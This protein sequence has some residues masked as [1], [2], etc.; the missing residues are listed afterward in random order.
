MVCSDDG[1]KR[2]LETRVVEAIA[3]KQQKGGEEYAGGKTLIVFLDAG[4]APAWYPNKVAKAVK[5]PILFGALWVVGLQGVEN[6][7]YV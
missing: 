7:E 3:D 2:D 4:N 1:D 6:G 5:Q